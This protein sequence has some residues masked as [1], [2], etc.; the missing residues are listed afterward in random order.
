MRESQIENYLKKEVEKLGGLC[1][2]FVSPG[3]AGVPDRIVL[4][5]G[6]KVIFVELKNGKQGRLSALQKRMQTVLKKLGM[7]TY[8]LKSYEEIDSLIAELRE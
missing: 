1:L 6:G 2:K 4:L 5:P 8:V 7:Q 3:H